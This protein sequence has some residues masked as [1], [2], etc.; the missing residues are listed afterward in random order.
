M[1]TTPD[2]ERAAIVDG[3]AVILPKFETL[4]Y[5][6]KLGRFMF[7]ANLRL[8]AFGVSFQILDAGILFEIGPV[9][10]AFAHIQRTNDHYASLERGD[11]KGE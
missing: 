2:Q 4:G 6:K 10:F 3:V 1:T 11:H 5:A 7:V 8:D 9:W